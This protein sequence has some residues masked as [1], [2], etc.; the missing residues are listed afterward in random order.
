MPDLPNHGPAVRPEAPA[1]DSGTG[2]VEV[3]AGLIFRHGRLLIT[4]RPCGTHL[5][6]LWEFP[7]G[8][9]EPGETYEACLH[10]ELKEELGIEVEPKE[11]LDSISH[12]YPEKRVH[13]GFYRCSCEVGEPQ[14]IGC[15]AIAW[16][17]PEELG[18]YAFPPAD[19]QLLTLLR[20]RPEIW[21]AG[22]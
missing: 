20:A 8:K 11:L 14:A 15:E 17:G 10:R 9:R 2:A 5:A 16:I 18:R 13:L 19:Q 6:G 22:S 3:A 12:T 7:G 4:R 1:E 21:T